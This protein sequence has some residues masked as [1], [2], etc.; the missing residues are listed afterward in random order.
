MASSLRAT[1][2]LRPLASALRPATGRHAQQQHH[3]QHH[4]HQHQHLLPRVARRH[5]S[6]P[7]GYTQAKAL[8][9]SKEGE[10]SDVLQLHTHSISPSIPS[11]AVLLRALAAPINPADVNTIQ[12]T[13][14]AKPPFTQLIGT[15]EP[16]AIPGNEGVFEVVSVGSRD[17]GLQKGDW[18]IPSAS[19]FGTWRTHAVADAKHV[20]KVSKEGLTPT[21]VATVSVNPCTAYRIL[22]TYGPGEIRAAADANPGAMRALDPGSG[23]WFIQNGANSGVGRAA[24]QL[25]KLWGLRS[26]NVVR[27][28]DTD[29]ETARL[30]D[31]LAG[32]G[33]TVVVTEKEF[34][35]RDWRDRLMDLTRAGRE[36]VGLGLNCVGGKSATAVARSL[37]EGATM[38][39]YGGMARQPVML[40]TGLL[41]FKDLRFVGFWLS[42]WNERDPRGRRFAVEDVLGMIREGRFRDVPVDEVPWHWDTEEKLLKDAVQGALGGFRKG[43]GVFVFGET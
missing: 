43:K 15:P 31:D 39:S 17:S 19:S 23:A 33:A 22:R 26:I 9:F 40:P 1:T 10:P 34:L 37:A 11:S 6:G 42:K 14:G 21:Q 30:K 25:G 2:T 24:I 16:A 8:V 41:I 29:A 35:A 13:Y 12:G 7:Y 3:H 5:K 27:E 36:P 32:L 20:M 18:V 38:V 4:Q 28:R